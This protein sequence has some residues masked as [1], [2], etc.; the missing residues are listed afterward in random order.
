MLPHGHFTAWWSLFFREAYASRM[1]RSVLARNPLSQRFFSS[2]DCAALMETC[3]NWRKALTVHNTVSLHVFAMWPHSFLTPA[4]STSAPQE[5]VWSCWNPIGTVQDSTEAIN[6]LRFQQPHHFF[7][8]GLQFWSNECCAIH[9]SVRLSFLF[10]YI[11][12]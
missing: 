3:F 1:I 4:Y 7:L 11:Y 5:H 12:I 6:C 8:W 2:F 9:G 10:A